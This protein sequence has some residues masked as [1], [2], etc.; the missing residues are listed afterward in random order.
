MELDIMQNIQP[1]S[2][3]RNQA[4]K[5]VAQVRKT[6]TPVLITQRG[7]S[8]AVLVDAEAYQKQL[9][10]LEL[11]SAIIRGEEDIKAGRIHTHADVMKDLEQ[12]LK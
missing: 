8:V 10:K 12:W 3:F 2:A 5:I 1:I 11:L 7:R 4:A 6:K 9:D